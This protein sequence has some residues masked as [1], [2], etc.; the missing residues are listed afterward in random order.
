VYR[1]EDVD[2]PRPDKYCE[3]AMKTYD[4]VRTADVW[5]SAR[6]FRVLYHL[7]AGTWRRQR[8]AIPS[9]R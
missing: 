5:Q 3:R 2:E 7:R 6:R 4:V 1:F 9:Y 8:L